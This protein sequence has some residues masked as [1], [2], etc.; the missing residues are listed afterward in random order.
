MTSGIIGSP[1]TQFQSAA[2]DPNVASRPTRVLR[3]FLAIFYLSIQV[4]V[5]IDL[6]RFWIWFYFIFQ[7]QDLGNLYNAIIQVQ[8]ALFHS[9]PPRAP[10]LM[11]K[12][13]N[14]TTLWKMFEYVIQ[15]NECRQT[16]MNLTKRW[17]F[18][19]YSFIR[20]PQ[21][22]LCRNKK[23]LFQIPKFYDDLDETI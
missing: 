14:L 20:F 17:L 4:C 8:I 7:I 5:H 6:Y 15:L 12:K 13:M 3:Y 9:P 22:G 10:R 18:D 2:K 23:I 19:Y 1:L 21:L 16:T 11:V